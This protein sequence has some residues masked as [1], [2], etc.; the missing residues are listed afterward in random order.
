MR[1]LA[2]WSLPAK[3]SKNKRG[4]V[5]PL[6]P[7]AL[8]EI[9]AAQDLPRGGGNFS[10]LKRRLD[11]ASGVTGWVLHDI[12]RTC[13][14]GLARLGIPRPVAEACLNHV[15]GRAGLVGVY[16]HYDYAPEV[17]DALL[18]WQT[19]IETIVGNPPGAEGIRLAPEA[20]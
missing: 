15:G 16:E 11:A 14:T 12:R 8:G 20:A 4:Y 1:P 2:R 6:G 17:I 5:L 10:E 3:R 19:H 7:L 18:R 9:T 13:R